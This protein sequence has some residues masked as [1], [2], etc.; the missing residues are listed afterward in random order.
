MAA[1][2][3]PPLPPGFKLDQQQAP[4]LPP[5]FTLDQPQKQPQDRSARIAEIERE[6]AE[7]KGEGFSLKNAAN[8]V[9]D[10]GKAAGDTALTLGSQA[11]LTPV[12]GVAGALTAPFAGTDKAADVVQSIQGAAYQPKSEVGQQAVE[13]I[14]KPLMWAVDKADRA[15]QFA[16]DATGSPAVGAAVNTGLQSIP[17]LLSKGARQPFKSAVKSGVDAVR[18][19][20]APAAKAAPGVASAA[21]A[22]AKQ[23]EAYARTAGVDWAAL[24]VQIKGQ[25]TSIAK[26]AG[27]L[28]GV[29]PEALARYA[30][31]QSLS[32]PVPATRGQILRDP[33]QLRNEGNVSAT[34]EGAPIR[35]IHLAANT[36][37]L[38]NLERLKTRVS[39][40][41]TTQATARSA[42]EAGG[43]VQGALRAKEAASKKG[44]D[45][46]YKTARETEPA[47]T[48]SIEPM[49]TLLNSNP[50]IQHLGWMEAWLGKAAKTN[51]DLQGNPTPITKATLAELSDLRSRASAIAKTGGK[52]GY[53]AGLVRNAIDD[54]M[55]G[56]PEGAKAW[57]A[58]NAA[59]KKH[60]TEF[61]EQGSVG[62]LVDDASRTDRV[63][64]LE[65]TVDTITNG[66]IEGIRQVK[67]SLLT[68]GDEAARTAGRQ[69]MR[70]IR[71][72]VIQRIKDMA[73]KSVAEN[74]DGSPNITAA[75]FKRALDA[76]GP[77]K[78]DEIFGPGTAKQLSTI[79]Q[80]AKDVKT[81]P[82]SAAVGSSTVA[83]ALALLGKGLD[84]VP[85]VGSAIVDVAKGVASVKN[86]GASA[87]AATTAQTVPLKEIAQQAAKK[88]G[89][90]AARDAVKT[91]TIASVASGATQQ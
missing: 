56:A 22:A 6:L 69:A 3:I 10:F 38:E 41:G 27:N 76:Y 90:R 30:R 66:P 8:A 5:G 44:Y 55:E 74:V 39:G 67:R 53:Y 65:K 24:P 35:D 25:L 4:P 1:S 31:L 83:N 78:L 71:A 28:D 79:L 63:T 87:R 88:A 75:G 81:L 9:L 52:E 50:E 85:I 61:S 73:T 86:M 59:F 33:V 77:Q 23:A 62:K 68:G 20:V 51:L 42:E 36:A 47:A 32:P 58:A 34:V 12:A 40:S 11:L 57:K 21:S 17:V 2:A 13:N 72:A 91:T 19:A 49:K 60:K 37:L 89:R 26:D 84:K 54:A 48:V 70:E 82:P 45:A 15:G 43:A 29:N 14:S 7:I 16:A 64:A 46:L 80:A 18:G